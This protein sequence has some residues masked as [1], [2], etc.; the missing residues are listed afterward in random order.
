M[1]CFHAEGYHRT[2]FD[3]G[4]QFAIGNPSVITKLLSQI[5]SFLKSNKTDLAPTTASPVMFNGT[6]LFWKAQNIH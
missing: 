5:T 3:L 2:A 1:A 6:L 4:V